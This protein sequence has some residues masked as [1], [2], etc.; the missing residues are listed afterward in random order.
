MYVGHLQLSNVI[1]V[2][3]IMR[4]SGG[5]GGQNQRYFRV[6]QTTRAVDQPD[7]ADRL[8]QLVHR[9]LDEKEE[10]EKKKRRIVR[11][12]DEGIEVSAWLD[13]T[14]WIRHLEGRDKIA[15][16][17][18]IKPAGSEEHGLQEVEK[19]IIRLVEQARQ[20]ILQKKVSIFTLQR[21][22]SFQLDQD[23]EKP[24]NYAG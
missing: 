17:L 24:N 6:Q 3:Y 5:D 13:R 15:I 10:E 12:S 4:E 23:A 14:Q 18:H 8:L 7:D 20:T 22:E 9:Q 16:A 2:K 21:L 19:S 11:E 1:S